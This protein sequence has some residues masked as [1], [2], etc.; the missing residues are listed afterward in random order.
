M[1]GTRAGALKARETNLKRHGKNFYKK[2]GRKGG[3]NG[4]GPDYKGGFGGNHELA[5]IAGAKGGK[6]SSRAGVKNGQGGKKKKAAKKSLIQ[7]IFNK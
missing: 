5:R 3:K 2:I 7:R 6:K 4:F 1:T